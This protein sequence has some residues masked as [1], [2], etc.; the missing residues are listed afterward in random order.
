MSNIKLRI[1][2]VRP[3]LDFNL[4]L[5]SLE[6]QLGFPFMEAS[7]IVHAAKKKQIQTLEFPCD[8]SKETI[9][10]NLNNIGLIVT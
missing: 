1:T 2:G 5:V 9:I 3:N 8:I 7:T 10:S 4:C 6:R